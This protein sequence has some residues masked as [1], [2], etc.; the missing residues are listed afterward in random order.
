MK[1][2]FSTIVAG[3]LCLALVMGLWGCRKLN[4]GKETAA[5]PDSKAAECPG[6]G[7]ALDVPDTSIQLKVLNLQFFRHIGK[8]P[9]AD[10]REGHVFA[11]LDVEWVPL[12]PVAAGNSLPEIT[13]TYGQQAPVALSKAGQA[14]YFA[15]QLEGRYHQSGA[16]F[17]HPVLDARV[18]ELPIQAASKGLFV[19]VSGQ[20]FCLGKW[21]VN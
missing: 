19:H 7:S 9:V 6:I 13:M 4:P 21:Q 18:Y 1:T 11:L 14:A 2:P 16:G 12:E 8:K 10:S 17:D 3:A 20:L 15:L 5:A